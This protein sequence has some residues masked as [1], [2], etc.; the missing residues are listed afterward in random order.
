MEEIGGGGHQTMAGAYIKA[1]SEETAV[2]RLREA[3]DTVLEAR[4]HAQKAQREQQKK[5]GE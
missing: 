3:I 5:A 2:N 1:D 4:E